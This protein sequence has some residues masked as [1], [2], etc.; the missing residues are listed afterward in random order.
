MRAYTRPM[1]C[2]KAPATEVK[3]SVL[4]RCA[5]EPA[6]NQ[7]QAVMSPASCPLSDQIGQLPLLF[8][9]GTVTLVSTSGEH[10]A[11]CKQYRRGGPCQ[12]QEDH[13]LERAD[14]MVQPADVAKRH[15]VDLP[16]TPAA[17]SAAV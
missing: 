16:D 15:A 8:D 7:P 6:S 5:T 2:C 14:V 9:H 4:Q 3:W 1:H 17:L 11:E 13:L 10:K 12:G